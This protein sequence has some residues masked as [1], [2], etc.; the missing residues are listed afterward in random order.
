VQLRVLQRR[1]VA[2]LLDEWRQ[3]WTNAYGDADQV[4]LENSVALQV[5]E[6][7]RWR[8]KFRY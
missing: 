7:Q 4:D 3:R 8:V 2:T 5:S 6:L 1:P